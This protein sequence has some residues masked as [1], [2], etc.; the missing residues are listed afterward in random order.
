[1][2]RRWAL[3]PAAI[4]AF[5]LLGPAACAEGLP[6]QRGGCVGFIG[7]SITY[8]SGARVPSGVGGGEIGATDAVGWVKALLAT[9]TTPTGVRLVV[10]SRPMAGSM[11]A[12]WIT[13]NAG[14]YFNAITGWPHMGTGF[15]DGRCV[16]V[17]V[18]LGIN[19]ARVG[20]ATPPEKYRQNLQAMIAN[21]KHDLPEAKVILNAP[22]WYD[23]ALAIRIAGAGNAPVGTDLLAAY[24][25]VLRGLAD[26]KTVFLGD[27]DG[28][29]RF[30][31]IDQSTGPQAL[32][33]PDGVHP[34]DAGYRLL[35]QFWFE[36]LRRVLH[37]QVAKATP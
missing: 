34:N 6:G 25:E 9:A 5:L 28:F 2:V 8:G 13:P 18:M 15:K 36:A 7:D 3:L 1:M 14:Y 24:I 21:L 23:S 4:A 16:A 27:T 31:A 30:K 33:G 12:E 35:G 17:M 32:Y 19:D 20:I 22:T 29:V 11:T 37:L 26:N 10:N